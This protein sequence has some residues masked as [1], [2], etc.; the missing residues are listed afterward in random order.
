MLDCFNML[1]TTKNKS[2]VW[3]KRKRKQNFERKRVNLE[4]KE[5]KLSA[6]SKGSSFKKR[7]GRK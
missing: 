5:S 3:G 1:L 2:V 4:R 7:D 6:K